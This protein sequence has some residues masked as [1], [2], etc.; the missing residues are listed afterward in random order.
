MQKK[1]S[2]KHR[3]VGKRYRNVKKLKRL[4]RAHR[5]LYKKNRRS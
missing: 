3:M 4:K 1:V 2:K 5:M